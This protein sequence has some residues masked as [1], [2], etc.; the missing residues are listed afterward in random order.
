[1]TNQTIAHARLINHSIAFSSLQTP[2]RVVSRLGAMQAQ[3]YVGA[4]W[5]VGLRVTNGTEAAV[6]EALAGRTIVRT[7]P[8]RGALHFVAAEDVRWMLAL[9]TPRIIA[10]S[11]PLL[12]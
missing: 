6:E 1:M 12:R 3:E 10:Q 8:M 5:S 9:L 4:L 2:A 11:A 7:L